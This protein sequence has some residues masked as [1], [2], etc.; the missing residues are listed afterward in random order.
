MGIVE[1]GVPFFDPS[2]ADKVGVD[3]GRRRSQGL[4][5]LSFP[6]I[7]LDDVAEIFVAQGM[8]REGMLHGGQDLG[9][10]VE[11]HQ[12]HNLFDLMGQTEFGF[13]EEFN[14]AVGGFSQGQQGVAVFEVGAV[15]FGG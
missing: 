6:A 15:G 5:G 11:L 1:T 8:V 13:G 4:R 2:G 12:L 14:I 10:A 3:F 7:R 9:F